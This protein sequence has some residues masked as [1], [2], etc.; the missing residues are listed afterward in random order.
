MCHFIHYLRGQPKVTTLSESEIVSGYTPIL[1]FILE[2]F[3]EEKGTD[4]FIPYI[5]VEIP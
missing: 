4:K 2:L 3:P 1:L 5:D